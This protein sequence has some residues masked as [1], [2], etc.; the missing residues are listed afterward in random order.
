[1]SGT[2]S[3]FDASDTSDDNVLSLKNPIFR[4]D[5]VSTK[6]R[7][8]IETINQCVLHTNS[9]IIVVSQSTK[10]LDIL[11]FHLGTDSNRQLEIMMLTG[12]TPQKNI[13][14]I[15]RDFNES[16]RPCVLLLSSKLAESNLNL[17][18]AKYL[19]NMDLHWNSNLEVESL[20]YRLGQEN[21]RVV[22]YQFVCLSSV[23][24][25]LQQV[26]QSKFRLA[27][28]YLRSRTISRVRRVIEFFHNFF[29]QL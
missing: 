26:Q 13:S 10:L 15:V 27:Y 11:N 12:I 25:R 19:I 14:K 8:A 23:D 3:N 2:Q 18:G 24:D 17:D 1:M 21:E 16:L 5:Y 9:K 6:I 29:L 7:K 4:L 20:I 28:N 22:F